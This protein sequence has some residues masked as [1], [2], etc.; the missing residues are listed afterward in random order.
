M[1]ERHISAEEQ[2][3]R[4][5]KARKLALQIVTHGGTAEE[6]ELFPP[7]AWRAFAHLA[8]VA[9]PSEG[10]KKTTINQLRALGAEAQEASA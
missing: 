5:T 4:A 6:A 9:E 1:P 3:G 8:W 7:S 2:E 10:T